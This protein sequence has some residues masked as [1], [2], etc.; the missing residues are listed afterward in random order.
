MRASDDV[1]A[2]SW[3][4]SYF[5]EDPEATM[6]ECLQAASAAHVNADRMAIAHEKRRLLTLANARPVSDKPTPEA[7]T[8][9]TSEPKMSEPQEAT[10]EEKRQWAINFIKTNPTVPVQNVVAQVRKHFGTGLAYQYVL[11]QA[12]VIRGKGGPRRKIT[13][14]RSRPVAAARMGREAPEPE[15]KRAVALLDEPAPDMLSIMR[16]LAQVMNK[17]Q[18]SRIV[19][20]F[21]ADGKL[22]WEGQVRSIVR[23]QCLV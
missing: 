21:G 11:E 3:I 7:P 8:P 6:E 19:V 4:R 10:K 14:V 12:R 2:V 1:E 18:M 22:N 20:D 17:R 5:Q 13:K 15:L 23:G 16:A 9:T